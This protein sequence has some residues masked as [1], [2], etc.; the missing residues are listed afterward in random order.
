MDAAVASGAKGVMIQ[1]KHKVGFAM[2][3]TSFAVDGY[4]PYGIGSTQWYANNG[5]P[6]VVGLQ[7]AAA[8]VRGL[9][10]S[11]YFNMGDTTWKARTGL[12]EVTG[13]AEMIAMIKSQLT[14]L[15]TNY[16][17]ITS[18]WFDSWKWDM[19]G[20]YQYIQFYDI[21][22][23]V[24]A[25]QP[26]CVIVDNN[27]EHPGQHPDYEVYEAPVD[28][29]IQAGNLRPAEE[30]DTI[31]NDGVWVYL[32][33]SDQT[34]VSMRTLANLQGAIDNAKANNGVYLLAVQPGPDGLIS[35]VQTALLGQLV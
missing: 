26:N 17:D 29:S 5:N 18:I 1:T 10:P 14:E 15:L 11:F 24:K 13:T 16:G 35:T 2:W 23:H 31:R 3:P 25:L 4:Q 21:Y 33:G 22:K 8:R 9:K 12:D 34:S 19:A 20:G 6:D 28:G 32:P 30:V 27:H 7:V